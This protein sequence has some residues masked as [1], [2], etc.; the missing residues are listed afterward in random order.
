MVAST[1]DWNGGGGHRSLPPTK[2][3][4]AHDRLAKD[5]AEKSPFDQMIHRAKGQKAAQRRAV[6]YFVA[7]GK[8][9]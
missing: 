3:V 5:H 8:R 7:Q 9:A 1:I 4:L 2:K 6:R